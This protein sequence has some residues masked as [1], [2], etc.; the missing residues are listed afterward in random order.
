MKLTKEQKIRLY[1]NMVRVRKLDELLQSGFFVSHKIRSIYIPQ[2]G[3]EA[4][5]VGGCTFLN[6]D[7]Y[8]FFTH[9]G[10][11]IAKTLPKGVPAG[12][13]AAEFYGKATGTCHGLSGFR[14]VYP[15]LGVI[16]L[17]GSVGTDLTIA[18]GTGIAAKRRGKG[19]VTACFFG[20]GA[21]N[22]GTF[23][24]SILTSANWKLP[25]VWICENNGF[26]DPTA[27]KDHYPKDNVADMAFG[28]GIPGVTV[29]G[30]DVIA[31]YEAV[32]TATERARAGEGPSLI[33]CK[34]LC[35]AA[36]PYSGPKRK[37][38]D[39]QEKD[40]IILFR[41]KLLKE[42]VITRADIDRI[43]REAAEEMEEAD[44]FATDSPLPRPE[45]LKNAL[46]AD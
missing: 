31:V 24:T 32:Q 29:D 17:S 37:K 23:H 22:R 6:K 36:D 40:P 11:G 15:D 4:V 46:Y 44:R 34:T 38:E 13:I 8:I 26:F 20:D 27:V 9:R 14:T 41:H 35:F 39:W 43:D 1:T 45:I 2:E 7:D 5:G 30:Q 18:T 10:M 12:A 21:M 28:Y 42:S 19:Q 33:E 25:M 3:Q 16:G